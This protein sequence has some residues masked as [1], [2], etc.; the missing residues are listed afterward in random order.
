LVADRFDLSPAEVTALVSFYPKLSSDRRG[1]VK[2]SFRNG[3]RGAPRAGEG[4][5]STARQESGEPAAVAESTPLLSVQQERRVLARCG[6]VDPESIEHAIA[7]GSYE[8]LKWALHELDPEEMIDLV[9]RSGLQERGGT[10]FPVGLKWTLVAETPSDLRYVIGNGEGGD[11]GLTVDRTLLEGDPH[12][13]LEG[14]LIAGLAVG[15]GAGRLVLRSEDALGVAR[16]ERAVA[17]ARA[18]GLVGSGILGSDFDFEIEIHE[19]AGASMGGEET[20]LL[21]IIQ[22][23]RAVA[24]P[25]PPFPTVTGLW[26][27]PTLINSLETLANIPLIVRGDGDHSPPGG[28]TKIAP[29]SGAVACPGLAEV[30]LGTTVATIIREI[31]GG[32][33][34]GREIRAVHVGG[35]GG[36]TLGPNS[37]DTP[38]D[39]TSI[40]ELGAS[41]GSG[42][43]VALDETACVVA[44][45]RRLIEYCAEESC[46]TCPPCRIGSRVLLNL[47][48]RILS[49]NGDASDLNALE[50]L[51]HHIRRTS[52]CE[53][54]R[55]APVAVIS[56]LRDFRD[57]YEAHIDGRGCP[58]GACSSMD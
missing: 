15:A 5:F 43:L 41:L 21:N 19:T 22:G 26:G 10:G 4:G 30:Q 3:T 51:C 23:Q 47:L 46:G 24:R 2:V 13:V 52:L 55:N 20:A 48:D 58:S 28:Q 53:L 56:G 49:G 6:V 38:L 34:D 33:R 1:G 8:S 18:R 37:F 36:V 54:G 9:K 25:R 7:L 11:P 16:A 40:R 29:L 44:F 17:E 14:L 32:G 57:E 12:G 27:R 42:G 39:Y 50:G 31:G 45:A 35:S